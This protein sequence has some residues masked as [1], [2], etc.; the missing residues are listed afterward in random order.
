M[1]A[2][3]QRV[4]EAR[5]LVDDQ[6]V[7]SIGRGLLVL[8]GIRATDSPRE[9]DA[10]VQKTLKIRLFPDDS[11]KMNRNVQEVQGGVLI[12]SQFTLYADTSKGNRP[13]FSAAA[14][15][16]HAEPLYERFVAGVSASGL[17]V[18]T[19]VFQAHM[20]VQLENDGPVTFIC[21]SEFI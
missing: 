14:P 20:R 13:S 18:E 2:L 3:L 17:H 12:V 1:I 11:G 10:L 16:D 5:V 21:Q 19:G 15:A 8:L 7:G 9:V 6:V 4:S